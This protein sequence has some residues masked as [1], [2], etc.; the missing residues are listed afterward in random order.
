M[1]QATVYALRDDIE[2]IAS[3][4][5][6]TLETEEYGLEPEPALFGSAD[7]WAAIDR[8][9]L[10]VPTKSPA[11]SRMCSGEDERLGDRARRV[12]REAARFS[13]Q[14]ISPPTTGGLSGL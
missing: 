4:Q 12:P 1:T 7:R 11:E 2:T 8:A 9:D 14:T 13:G 6:A 3:I 5:R 10:L